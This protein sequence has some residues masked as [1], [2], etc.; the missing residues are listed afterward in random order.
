MSY[1][2]IPS[3]ALIMALVLLL[4]FSIKRVEEELEIFLL[5]MGCAAMTLSGLWNRHIVK[6]S[7]VEPINISIAV[8]V[9]GFMFRAGRNKIENAIER[10]EKNIG[11]NHSLFALIVFLGFLSSLITAIVAALILCEVISHLRLD[12]PSRIRTAVYACYAIGM[13][14]ALTPL[15]EP[16][17]T[18]V[19]AKLQ[20]PPHNAGF[21]WLANLLFLWVTP[22][23]VA[24]AALAAYW[25]PLGRETS[26]S[27]VSDKVPDTNKAVFMRAGKV[28]IFVVALVYL[29]EGVK[30]IANKLLSALE[31]WQF[32]WLGL[33]SAA[34]DNATLAAA[35][36]VPSMG[37]AQILSFV[38]S[39]L[40]SGGILIPGNIPNIISA[41]KL[42]V[43]SR[44]WAR[45]AIPAGVALLVTYFLALAVIY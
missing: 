21:F 43:K 31:G 5:V 36:I 7:F 33:T 4:P 34:L 29:G 32:Y 17:S 16:L 44:E 37:R 8:L 23:I 22:A 42:G 25:R 10:L 11:L 1:W 2:V 18:I 26:T 12:R 45:A 39:L 38:L 35:G 9:A 15:G 40:I 14:A 30:P 27:S 6:E 19:T 41:A 13:G 28:Y 24:V 3:L 20:G